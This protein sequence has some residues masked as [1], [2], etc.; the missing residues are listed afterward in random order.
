MLHCRF[1]IFH[2]QR[3][4]NG[5]WTLCNQQITSWRKKA[6]KLQSWWWLGS[7]R[8]AQRNCL[9]DTLGWVNLP[10]IAFSNFLLCERW[11]LPMSALPMIP[12]DFTL[13][14]VPWSWVQ[15]FP[16]ELRRGLQFYSLWPM[17]KGFIKMEMFF[18][19]FA[20]WYACLHQSLNMSASHVAAL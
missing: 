2:L 20:V 7:G 8:A 13:P 16:V 4:H 5:N 1:E 19:I 10:P 9:N 14:C 18:Q 11:L 15:G 17:R 3:N 12:I 6:H